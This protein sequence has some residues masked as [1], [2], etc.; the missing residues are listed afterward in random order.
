MPKGKFVAALILLLAALAGCKKADKDQNAIRAA[1]RDHLST[2]PSINISAMDMD[3]K[4]VTIDG[5]QAQAEVEFRAKQGGGAVT[6]T[7]ALERRGDSWVVKA[8]QTPG[9]MTHPGVGT[10][11]SPTGAQPGT[12]PPG[13]PPLSSPPKTPSQPTK[14]P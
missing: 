9:G 12:L 6:V 10:D 4:K 1:L 11:A 3:V 13:H 5:N 14:N 2:R 8:S 7:Y